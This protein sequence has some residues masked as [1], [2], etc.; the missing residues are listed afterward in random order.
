M[1][2]L[3][4]HDLVMLIVAF[5]VT[6]TNDRFFSLVTNHPYMKDSVLIS[7]NTIQAISIPQ[8]RRKY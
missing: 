2:F 5:Y 6:K 3:A 8:G 4:D 7:K 1:T